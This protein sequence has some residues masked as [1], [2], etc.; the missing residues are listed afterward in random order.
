MQKLVWFLKKG[1]LVGLFLCFSQTS[2]AKDLGIIGQ[3]YPIVETDF[4]EWIKSKLLVMQQNGELSSAQQQLL[5][6]AKEYMVRPKPVVIV[7][8]ATENHSFTYD[9]SVV[10]PYDITDHLGNIIYH[11]GTRVN[12]LQKM[13]L[14]KALLFFDSDDAEQCHWAQQIDSEL[15]GKDKVILVKGDV[16]AQQKVWQRTIYFD[17]QGLITKRLGIQHVPVIVSQQDDHLLIREIKL[18]S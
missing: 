14:S 10:V 2:L 5:R 11:A 12:P 18:S 4:L 17:Q 8:R 7:T 13:P 15:K 16:I 3:T 6:N 1:L 9:P